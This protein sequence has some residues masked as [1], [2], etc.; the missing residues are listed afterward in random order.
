MAE[1]KEKPLKILAYVST[2]AKIVAS[3]SATVFYIIKI[4]KELF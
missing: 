1:K 4:L 3:V 2:V